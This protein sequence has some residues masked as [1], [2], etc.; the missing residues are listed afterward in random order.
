MVL[1][2]EGFRVGAFLSAF[3]VDT[4]ACAVEHPAMIL[5]YMVP[6]MAGVAVADERS[7]VCTAIDE[8]IQ[9]TLA[10]PGH[11]DGLAADE[12]AKEIV[13]VGDLVFNTK[14]YPALLEDIF[15]F[16]FENGPFAQSGSV[17]PEHALIRA[18]VDKCLYL[19]RRHPCPAGGYSRSALQ[20]STYPAAN[21]RDLISVI[22]RW[23]ADA[24]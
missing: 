20:A 2:V 9:V 5:A 6:C 24:T 19:L 15:L 8:A 3:N 10:V 16:E 12:R 7:P 11:D 22:V 4:F 18:V 14:K 1:P 13:L 17:D 23:R 21:V